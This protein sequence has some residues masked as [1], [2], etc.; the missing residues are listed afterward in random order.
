[1]FLPGPMVSF[2]SAREVSSCL[3]RAKVY[4]LERTGSS[5]KC[6]KSR[7]QVS[8]NVN[9]TDTFTSTVTN[10]THKII[11]K[12]DWND[13]YF[14]YLLTCRKFLIQYFS[15]TVDEF[16]DRWNNYKNN[17][18]NYDCNHPCMQRHL[19]D[20]YSSV[21]HSR[22]LEQVLIT[23]I[24]KTDTSDPLKREYYWSRDSELWSHMVLI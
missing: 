6:K 20:H 17:T 4:P 15:K 12:S 19:Y 24:D 9:E 3:V 10:K 23:F 22:F 1:M 18:R 21:G 7:C 14:I 2:Q 8:L 13:K 11:H 16:H 5:F